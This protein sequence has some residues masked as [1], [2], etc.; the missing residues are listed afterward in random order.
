MFPNKNVKLFLVKFVSKDV[1]VPACAISAISW[2][3]REYFQPVP[4]EL[5]QITSQKILSSRET[6]RLEV[7]S[8]LEI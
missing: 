3:I 2:G 4:R 8:I 7:A 1:P 5:V 6:G